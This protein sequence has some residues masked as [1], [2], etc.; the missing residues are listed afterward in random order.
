MKRRVLPTVAGC[1]V[2]V[3]ALVVSGC[4]T[5]DSAKPDVNQWDTGTY[6]TTPAESTPQLQDSDRALLEAYRLAD[7]V[8]NPYEVDSKYGLGA[9]AGPLPDAAS[10][11]KYLVPPS[12]AVLTKHRFVQG[13]YSSAADNSIPL[14]NGRGEVRQRE[15]VFVTVLR[16]PSVDEAKSAATELDSVDF[17]WNPSNVAVRIPGYP[18]SSAHWRPT[19]PTLG[20]S[21]PHGIYV[22]T[23]LAE[24]RKTDLSA[25]TSMTRKYLDAEIPVLDQFAPTPTDKWNTLRQDPDHLLPGVL[26]GR[27]GIQPPTVAGDL[28]L[29]RRGYLNYTTR[30]EMTYYVTDQAGRQDSMRDAGVDLV[31]RSPLSTVFRAQSDTKAAS[32][33]TAYAK[34]DSKGYRRDVDPPLDI[35]DAVCYEQMTTPSDGRFRCLAAYHRFAILVTG[36][37]LY[38]LQ[39][40]VTAQYV[41]LV[42]S[43]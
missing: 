4:G 24:T 6:V 2:A 25:L 9:M 18:D 22:I 16:F 43:Q 12:E 30:D 42:N 39:Q 11:A 14:E 10:A 26:H 15:G 38:D 20:S 7:K 19:V 40:R 36:D 29:T 5:S 8:L 21:T 23:V 1:F 28:V 41:L 34:I 37:Q 32:L 31:L 27:K 35:T 3:C 13:F 17:G 33:V